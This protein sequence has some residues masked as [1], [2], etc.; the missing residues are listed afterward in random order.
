MFAVK[1]EP[2]TRSG[3]SIV[4]NG[5]GIV[6]LMFPVLILVVDYV[7]KVVCAKNFFSKANFIS[8]FTNDGTSAN[9]VLKD[10]F[11]LVVAV[12]FCSVEEILDFAS[13]YG[14]VPRNFG[15]VMPTVLVLA[16]T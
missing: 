14:S 4:G 5:K 3:R 9:L 16:F 15:T 13:Y 6:S 12:Y 11:T 10:F 8:T 2:C 7:V 1:S